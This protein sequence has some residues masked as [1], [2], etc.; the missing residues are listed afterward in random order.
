LPGAVLTRIASSHIRVGTLF[1]LRV[2]MLMAFATS[3]I[4]S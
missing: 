2:E 3:Q 4:T 1:S